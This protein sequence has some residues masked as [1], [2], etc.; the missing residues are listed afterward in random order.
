[1]GRTR[2]RASRRNPD[3]TET[4][5]LRGCYSSFTNSCYRAKFESPSEDF[6]ELQPLTVEFNRILGEAAANPPDVGLELAIVAVPQSDG[7]DLLQLDWIDPR[8][9]L[10]LYGN[11]VTKPDHSE[12]QG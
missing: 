4:V 8:L 5:L 6:A 2:W 3:G 11:E 7:P 12:D 10:I 9:E 1:M